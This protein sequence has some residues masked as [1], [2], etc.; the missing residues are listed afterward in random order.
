MRC[1]WACTDCVV[2]FVLREHPGAG[3]EHSPLELD[4]DEA[5]VV[6][7]FGRAGLVPR[8]KFEAVG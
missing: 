7:L 6:Q 2:T 3:G 1:S 5:R 8:L 4:D